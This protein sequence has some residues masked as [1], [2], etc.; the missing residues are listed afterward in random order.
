MIVILSNI[1]VDQIRIGFSA[2]ANAEE[3]APSGYQVVCAGTEDSE[4]HGP[5]EHRNVRNRGTRLWTA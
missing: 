3:V 5:I 1:P 4:Y 2:Y